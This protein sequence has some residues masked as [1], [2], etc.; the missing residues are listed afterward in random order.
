M[1]KIVFIV[2]FVVSLVADLKTLTTKQV[3]T[4]VKDGKIAVI[5]IR[6][7]DEFKKYGV[8]KGSHKLTFFDNRGAYD[9]EKWMAKFTKIVKTKDTPFVLVCAHANRTKV[10]GK[11]LSDN[12]YKN[13]QELDGGINYGWLDKGKKTIK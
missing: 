11:F 12:G 6:R 8:I 9:V 3:E 10:V 13:T 4:I 2:L 7:D 5:D 1:K